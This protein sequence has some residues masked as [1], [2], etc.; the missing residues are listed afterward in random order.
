M[1]IQ[2]RSVNELPKMNYKEKVITKAGFLITNVIDD[3]NGGNKFD[4]GS[5]SLDDKD[6]S[7]LFNVPKRKYSY[8]DWEV[9]PIRI[10]MSSISNTYGENQHFIYSYIPDK[11]PICFYQFDAICSEM[12][13]VDI[14]NSGT[15]VLIIGYKCG[16]HS[17]GIKIFKLD[18]DLNF[19][20][21]E[22]S[23]IG[24]D[25]PLITWGKTIN[26]EFYIN[27]YSKNWELDRESWNSRYEMF[28]YK[29]SKFELHTT[30]KVKWKD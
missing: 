25:F 21:I 7:L 19:F 30:T 27:T 23:N 11:A 28:I 26:Q 16:A 15:P 29:N 9:I 4:W 13:I 24:S 10:V 12:T 6:K 18:R 3:N 8:S 2:H 20:Q 22:D 1:L 5:S 17:E 14:D